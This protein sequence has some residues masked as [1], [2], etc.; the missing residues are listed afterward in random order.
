MGTRW[1]PNHPMW[2]QWKKDSAAGKVFDT[3]DGSK[4]GTK[5]DVFDSY[6]ADGPK[7]KLL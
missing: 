5:N 7:A 6:A 4:V 1:H 3:R 2:L